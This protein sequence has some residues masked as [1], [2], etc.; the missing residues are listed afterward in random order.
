MLLKWTNMVLCG[1]DVGLPIIGWARSFVT[2]SSR[3]SKPIYE[4]TWRFLS[5]NKTGSAFGLWG[6]S[7]LGLKHASAGWMAQEY[8][9]RS[10]GVRLFPLARD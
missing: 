1:S 8:L 10:D 2:S 9:R 3:S 5:S 7:Q 4:R 6:T